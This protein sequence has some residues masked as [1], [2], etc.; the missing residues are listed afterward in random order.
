MPFAS[1]A[2]FPFTENGIAKYAP[3]GSGVYGIFNSTEWI[4]VGESKDMEARLFAHLRGESEQSPCILRQ[5]P[6]GYVFETC[7]A[8]ARTDRESGLIR[9]LRPSN[10]LRRPD[11]G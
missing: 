5:K 9:E 11:Q 4:Y 6:T 8:A 10:R 2:N 7:D 1:A 3:R